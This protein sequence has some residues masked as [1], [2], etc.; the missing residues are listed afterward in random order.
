MRF[1]R[2]REGGGGNTGKAAAL[3]KSTRRRSYIF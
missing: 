3:G 1:A 2:E